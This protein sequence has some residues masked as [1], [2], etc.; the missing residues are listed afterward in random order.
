LAS[1]SWDQT[2]KVWD[3][4]TDKLLLVW[5]GQCTARVQS[6][7]F[8][9][10]GRCLAS[11]SARDDPGY[12]EGQ[13][14]SGELKLWDAATGRPIW[15]RKMPA[16]NLVFHPDSQHVALRTQGKVAVWDVKTG[17]ERVTFAESK[18]GRWL[19]L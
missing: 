13:E 18:P 11:G 10:D 8:S 17:R 15:S 19:A 5:E 4:R 2:V 16:G 14:K 9:P 1:G 6:V 3:V 7:A 12:G